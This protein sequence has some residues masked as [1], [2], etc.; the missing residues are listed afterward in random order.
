M[1]LPLLLPLLEIKR[2]NPVLFAEG[3]SLVSLLFAV[4]GPFETC[5][6]G[7]ALP[8]V[9]SGIELPSGGETT[10]MRYSGEGGGS[11]S[12]EL[13]VLN[14]FVSSPGVS[15][16]GVS[17]RAGVSDTGVEAPLFKEVALLFLWYGMLS[18]L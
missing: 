10:T 14:E 15:F 9:G 12:L 2:P 16:D 1:T 6:V 3:L 7:E 4:P 13:V 5:G 8:V 11:F 18:W 17:G